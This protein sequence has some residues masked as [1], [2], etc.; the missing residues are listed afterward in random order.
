DD[1]SR[2]QSLIL[3]SS[4]RRLMML[5]PQLGRTGQSTVVMKKLAAGS[6]PEDL[7]TRLWAHRGK[8]TS[9]AAVTSLLVHG[10]DLAEAGGRYVAKP[11]IES[12]IRRV[13]AP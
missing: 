8:L 1:L 2:T 7:I 13:V 10:D 11:L 12:G 5:A 3:R 6:H 4:Q 9:A